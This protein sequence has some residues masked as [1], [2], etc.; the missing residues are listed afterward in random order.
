MIHPIVFAIAF[1]REME[2]RREAER[3]SR[4]LSH[5]PQPLSR[6]EKRKSVFSW[7]LG[8]ARRRTVSEAC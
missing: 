2:I 8:W 1:E 4:Y 7:L 3:N 6:F 5:Y